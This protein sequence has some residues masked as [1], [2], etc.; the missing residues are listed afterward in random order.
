MSHITC[1]RI[2]SRYLVVVFVAVA[3]AAVVVDDVAA[4]RHV[5]VGV[6]DSQGSQ[7]GLLEPSLVE[8]LLLL[9][10]QSRNEI[11]SH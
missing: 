9:L 1:L 6:E 10:L 8:L 3:V 5:E 11:F 2:V 4:C 7:V